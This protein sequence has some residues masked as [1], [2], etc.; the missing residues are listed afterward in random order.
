MNINESV[1]F[2]EKPIELKY[3]YVVIEL[4]SADCF[5]L[6]TSFLQVKSSHFLFIITYLM[7]GDEKKSI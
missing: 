4:L 2:T 6:F 5:P 3:K 7:P 1:L